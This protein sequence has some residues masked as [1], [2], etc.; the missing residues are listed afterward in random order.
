MANDRDFQVHQEES[1]QGINE[2]TTF[3][4]DRREDYDY[5]MGS[6]SH[7][8]Q[9][10]TINPN[11]TPLVR[12]LSQ[13]FPSADWPCPGPPTGSSKVDKQLQRE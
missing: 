3:V 7:R 12:W 5:D 13:D 4:L 8:S 9:N 11:G 6:P 2:R 1:Q 10:A